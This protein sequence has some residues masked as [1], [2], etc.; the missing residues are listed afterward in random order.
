MSPV[1][2]LFLGLLSAAVGLAALAWSPLVFGTELNVEDLAFSNDV[3][4]LNNL[5]AEIFDQ[6]AGALSAPNVT[7]GSSTTGTV[8][9]T[10]M[11]TGSNK[12]ATAISNFFG[13]T[14]SVTQVI[15]L[16]N[17]GWGYGEIF[18]LY[19]LA[20]LSGKTPAEIQAMRDEDKMGWGV[21]ART[22]GLAPG[23]KGQNLG[24]AVSG[25][26]IST[27]ISTTVP[28]GGRGKS[29]GNPHDNS[30]SNGKNK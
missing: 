24:A 10:L 20:Q 9:S 14:I 23:N 27:T 2:L 16:H 8:S 29:K 26:G 3:A 21:I 22:L 28:S 18:R 17:S 4:N 11:L 13:G 19:L 25:R 12:I 6:G 1:K 7:V 15:S 5:L 30:S